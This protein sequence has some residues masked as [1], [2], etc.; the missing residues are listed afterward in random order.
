MAE[1]DLPRKSQHRNPFLPELVA[2]EEI[3]ASDPSGARRLWE[4]SINK[5][6]K[7]LFAGV[8]YL[9]NKVI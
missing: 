5:L 4:I 8:I 2:E 6:R 3:I 9:V 1:A 7:A